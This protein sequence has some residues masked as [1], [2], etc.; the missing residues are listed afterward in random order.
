MEHHGQALSHWV[1]F[2]VVLAMAS[3]G[4]H[5]L[6]CGGGRC[7]GR[8]RRLLPLHHLIDFYCKPLGSAPCNL[9]RRVLGMIQINS[10]AN[11]RGE[12]EEV[13]KTVLLLSPGRWS[14]KEQPGGVV[15][16]NMGWLGMPVVL[17]GV[18]HTLWLHYN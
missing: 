17:V 18:S 5:C 14:T 3:G 12:E 16:V 9:L 7:C 8:G 10:P 15:D 11:S 6:S 4:P 1:G 2:T 13:G